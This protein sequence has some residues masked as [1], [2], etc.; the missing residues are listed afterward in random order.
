MVMPDSFLIHD[1]RD[2]QMPGTHVLVIG[3]GEYP[4]LLGG[5]PTR[6]TE[7][8][9]N[10]RQLTSPPRSA[11]DVASWFLEHF[12][13]PEHELASLAMLISEPAPTVPFVDSKGTLHQLA[14]ATMDNIK[15]AVEEWFRRADTHEDNL[16]IFYFCGHGLSSGAILALL[17]EDFGSNDLNV[18]D[19]AFDFLR[20]HL[21]M[22]N[23]KAQ[24][25][26]YFVDACRSQSKLIAKADSAGR[27]IITA[28][29]SGIWTQRPVYYATLSGTAA[30]G[31]NNSQSYFT[32]ALLSALRGSG[33]NDPEGDWRVTTTALAEA[34]GYHMLRQMKAGIQSLQIQP[35]DHLVLF[36]VCRLLSDPEVPV[37][38]SCSPAEATA[39]GRLCYGPTAAAP[40]PITAP[41]PVADQ[42]EIVL[43]PGLYDFEVTF[44]APTRFITRRHPSCYV[45][46]P[47][48]RFPLKVME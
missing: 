25:Q 11:K 8:H 6:A 18:L 32:E 24:K 33:S 27:V 19:H 3:V 7:K 44:T 20:L 4:C 39:A 28:D 30:Y 23:C 16:S 29:G 17:A 12:H 13:N 35:T 2:T 22:A 43:T 26:L 40:L 9:Q 36:D 15:L 41:P 34:I 21:G 47:Y 37:F 48:R 1:S 42:W 31:R 38:V 45:R 10:L 46:P 14:R 5:D